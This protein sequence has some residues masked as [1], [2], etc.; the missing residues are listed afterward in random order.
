MSNKRILLHQFVSTIC[1]SVSDHQPTAS[2]FRKLLM[3][4][5]VAPWSMAK[6][7]CSINE[8]PEDSASTKRVWLYAIPPITTFS[9]F[10][11]CHIVQFTGIEGLWAVA[12]FWYFG[13]SACLAGIRCKVRGV[14]GIN[15]NMV[16]DFLVSTFLYPSVS[17][18]LEET[19]ES[20]F[21]VE[22]TKQSYRGNLTIMDG[23]PASAIAG[24]RAYEDNVSSTNHGFEE[25]VKSSN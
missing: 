19:M 2:L 23:A 1:F 11:I 16:E 6:V 12:W 24:T 25:E 5:F 9:L 4:I 15:G 7:A 10:I 22:E 17:L 18:Q 20:I 21:I 8:T 13:F 14:V 3:H